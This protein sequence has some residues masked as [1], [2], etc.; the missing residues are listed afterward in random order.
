MGVTLRPN[1]GG[2]L[3]WQSTLNHPMLR[4]LEELGFPIVHPPNVDDP[5]GFKQYF[6]ADWFVNCSGIDLALNKCTDTTS[7]Y[8]I[9]LW[10]LDS[11]TYTV[12]DGNLEDTLLAFPD[13]ALKA[14][15][16]SYWQFNDGAISYTNIARYLNDIVFATL[17]IQRVHNTTIDCSE[18]VDVTSLEFT[19]R[20]S[21]GVLSAAPDSGTYACR[22]NLQ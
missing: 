21:G 11:R 5:W 15:Q 17:D 13:K 10:L 3:N 7:A 9:D 14:K 6:V 20:L 18:N 8:P 19:N 1:N 4:T 12:V 22:G 2:T 16:Y